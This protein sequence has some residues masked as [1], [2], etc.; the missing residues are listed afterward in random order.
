MKTVIIFAAAFAVPATLLAQG[1]IAA[2][3]GAPVASMK[4]LL[5]VWTSANAAHIIVNNN[6]QP[7][8]TSL[9]AAKDPRIPINA[10]NTPGTA[11]STFRIAA[12]GSY[13]LT[14]NFTGSSG[15]VGIEIASNE[16]T[17]D[18]MGFT[19]TGVVGSYDGIT[20]TGSSSIVIQNGTIRGFY[21][22]GI[23]LRQ[24][25]GFSQGSRIE[26]IIATGNVTTGIVCNIGAIIRRCIASGNGAH[27]FSVWDRSSIDDCVAMRNSSSGILCDSGSKISN[28]VSNENYQDGIL[29]TGSGSFL[30]NNTCVSNGFANGNGAGIHLSGTAFTNVLENNQCSSA[31]RGV[32]VNGS[33][34]VIIRNFCAFNTNN[35]DI[36]VNNIYGPIVN[37][38]SP[39]S[40]AATGN[41][42]ASTLGTTDP[43]ANFSH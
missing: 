34:N 17:I 37:R 33:R 43:N 7:G 19:I 30:S 14:G 11:T 38:I 1:P 42:A 2:P 10:T 41:S 6:I 21:G 4:T 8:V 13:Y 29:V 9:L 3:V 5:E 22:D 32:E 23:D 31:E 15:K 40:A 18:L 25:D 26:G 16:V 39:A 27:G 36:A 28:C 35:W 12:R 24:N 20:A